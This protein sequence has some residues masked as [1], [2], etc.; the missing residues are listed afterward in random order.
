MKALRPSIKWVLTFF[1]VLLVLFILKVV[2][3]LTSKPKITVNY[4]AESPVAAI[5]LHASTMP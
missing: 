5:L 1:G 4:V 2:L 3:L